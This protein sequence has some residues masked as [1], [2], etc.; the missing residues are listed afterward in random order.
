MSCTWRVSPPPASACR[1]SKRAPHPREA[2][3]ASLQGSEGCPLHGGPGGCG[4]PAVLREAWSPYQPGEL[5]RP[6]QPGCCSPL[7]PWRQG[8]PRAGCQWALGSG[9]PSPVHL[10][11]HPPGVCWA[12]L[13]VPGLQLP[14]PTSSNSQVSWDAQ[15]RWFQVPRICKTM[16]LMPD[17][18]VASQ[19]GKVGAC[20]DPE[21]GHRPEPPTPQLLGSGSS[22]LS[23]AHL[24]TRLHAPLLPHLCLG[25][26]HPPAPPIPDQF[27]PSLHPTPALLPRSPPPALV[28]L[29]VHLDV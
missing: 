29:Q 12:P 4:I 22:L 26:P 23:P 21:G 15:A 13:W 24:S 8:P 2:P 17:E 28:H 7:G 16:D 18:Q 9:P 11:D 1:W 3:L 25:H 27:P 6:F 5:A 10:A 20:S 19:R 14:R